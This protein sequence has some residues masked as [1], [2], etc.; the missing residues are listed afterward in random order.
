MGGRGLLTLLRAAAIVIIATGLN[1]VI[2]GAIPSYE[3]LYLYLAAVALVAVLDGIIP[4]TLTAALGVAFYALLFMPRAEATSIRLAL[5]AGL[6]FGTAI[7]V[8]VA[9]GL[10][11]RT[12]RRSVGPETVSAPSQAML[13]PPQILTLDSSEILLAIDSLR[14]D[15]RQSVAEAA[16][17]REREAMA[18]D[19]EAT[20]ERSYAQAREALAG[21]LHIAEEETKRL[22][23]AVA[24]ERVRRSQAEVTL[25]ERASVV[26][27]LTAARDAALDQLAALREQ[28]ARELAA[29]QQRAGQLAESRE[30]DAE[31]L[32]AVKQDAVD[33][34]AAAKKETADLAAARRSADERS[35]A[36]EREAATLRTRVQALEVAVAAAES[37]RRNAATLHEELE[38]ARAEAAANA[39]QAAQRATEVQTLRAGFEELRRALEVEKGRSE[40]ERG[41][42]TTAVE[43]VTELERTLR[44]E[45]EARERELESLRTQL[46]DVERANIELQKQASSASELTSKVRDLERGLAEER[47]ARAAVQSELVRAQRSVKEAESATGTKETELAI[48]RAKSGELEQTID[49]LRS[50]T[51]T[52][53]AGLER[54]LASAGDDLA[55][56]SR[57]LAQRQQAEVELR[58]RIAELEAAHA[59][60]RSNTDARLAALVAQH[61]TD[62]AALTAEREEMLAGLREAEIR[63]EELNSGLSSASEREGQSTE[64]RAQLDAT[65]A[66]LAKER[67]ERAAEREEAD[68][69]FATVAA[70]L[71]EDHEADLGRVV[72]EREEARAE[73]RAAKTQIESLRRKEE[74]A[75]QQHQQL[76][77]RVSDLDAAL[78]RER[79]ERDAER[80]E[81]EAQLADTRSQLTDN[82]AIIEER[83]TARAELR[84]ASF[85]IGALEQELRK[86]NAAAGDRG[87]DVQ[88][89][90]AQLEAALDEERRARAAA[91]AEFDENLQT[92]VAH[93]AHDHETDLGK[94]LEEKEA[95]RAEARSLSMRLGTIQKKVEEERASILAR[96]REAE[97]RQRQAVED[98]TRILSETRR[99]AQAEIDRLR[100][101]IAEMETREAF[102]AAAPQAMLQAPP[103]VAPRATPPPAAEKAARPLVL[104][105]HADAEMRMSARLNLE[106]AGYEVLGA[107][108]GLEA[109]RTATAVQP[110]V[111]I[112]DAVL[113]KMGGRELCQLLKSQEKTAAIRVV[114][115]TRAVDS[116]Q[117]GEF[118]PDQVLS[119]P[120][121]LESLKA[122][123]AGLLAQPS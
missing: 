113:P 97:E 28:S 90:V 33:R 100:Q 55:A 108:D 75:A 4:A 66:L 87:A 89:K 74:A 70:H 60:D 115:L 91:Q 104:V 95:A 57:E 1:D 56:G 35:V 107:A 45:R 8:S 76:L 116:P 123:L 52:M 6:A 31:Q 17:A 43:R 61:A 73:L 5:P 118:P 42:R 109:L 80:R 106:R 69:K 84:A 48:L 98:S 37:V 30:K 40:G 54:K 96:L 53:V 26:E 77:A 103:A 51:A 13:P 39:A 71:A 112:A 65:V 79:E 114:L 38:T 11:R 82:R 32:A 16:A 93:L 19:R 15:L 24:D 18:R 99:A 110:D 9:R 49:R 44:L 21:R 3:P 62:L 101:K 36:A 46:V 59:T 7:L 102:A 29:A 86:A 105:A 120:V 67:A 23:E 83:E 12:T 41:I 92:I 81:R 121:P 22:L 122:T 47:Q 63:I 78:A 68:A 50:E 20:L 88:A 94:A 25:R 72:E 64:L 117:H 34:L 111:V 119:K 2:A 27:Q 10:W 85:R 14:A 58:A